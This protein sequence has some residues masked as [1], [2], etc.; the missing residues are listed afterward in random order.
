MNEKKE[1]PGTRIIDLLTGFE[2][3]WFLECKLPSPTDKT[4]IGAMVVEFINKFGR[5]RYDS[6]FFGKEKK[7]VYQVGV[8]IHSIEKKK[9]LGKDSKRPPAYPDNEKNWFASYPITEPFDSQAQERLLE[10]YERVFPGRPKRTKEALAWQVMHAHG[11]W[12]PER[13]ETAKKTLDKKEAKTMTKKKYKRHQHTIESDN[14]IKVQKHPEYHATKSIEVLKDAFNRLFA[15]EFNPPVSAKAYYNQSAKVHGYHGR[16][17]GEAKKANA[18]TF[19]KRRTV[20][21]S[22]LE[23]FLKEKTP[24]NRRFRVGELEALRKE[25]EKKF[26]QDLPYNP[27]K[28]RVR[29][30]RAKGKAEICQCISGKDSKPDFV[31]HASITEIIPTAVDEKE[32]K[33][34][35]GILLG[36]NLIW[37]GNHK[38]QTCMCSGVMD[39]R[40]ISVLVIDE[41]IFDRVFY[42]DSDLGIRVIKFEGK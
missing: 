34:P 2:Y 7:S 13:K 11:R 42:S 12:N 40:A 27:F 30:A 36:G 38:P 9:N 41:H 3:K 33:D 24:L 37:Q 10:N 1:C 5:V 15:N 31:L 8:L 25:C 16:V 22:P 20:E 17:K 21:P 4:G 32:K 19:S 23:E 14:W 35:Y 6:L 29:K 18:L 28:E 26:N 39:G